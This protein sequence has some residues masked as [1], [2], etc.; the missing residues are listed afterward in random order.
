MDKNSMNLGKQ[1]NAKSLSTL[2]CEFAK[3]LEA[4][5]ES[6]KATYAYAEAAV[7]AQKEAIELLYAKSGTPEK[8]KEFGDAKNAIERWLEGAGSVAPN[9]FGHYFMGYE[10]EKKAIELVAEIFD[11]DLQKKFKSYLEKIAKEFD[12][13]EGW[14]PIPGHEYT[15]GR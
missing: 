1:C 2:Y 15:H 7:W 9:S 11:A 5:G 8:V 10:E 4:N 3:V 12:E 6:E 14:T 13:C